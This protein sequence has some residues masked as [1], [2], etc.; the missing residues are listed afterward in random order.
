MKHKD[1]VITIKHSGKKYNS[2]DCI[3]IRDVLQND[4]NIYILTTKSL[5][6]N[7]LMNEKHFDISIPDAKKCAKIYKKGT[8]EKKYHVDGVWL[9]M[10]HR[11]VLTHQYFSSNFLMKFTY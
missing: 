2:F 10:Y 4:K 3:V 6:R 5:V 7:V 1:F 9:P 8:N 11:C